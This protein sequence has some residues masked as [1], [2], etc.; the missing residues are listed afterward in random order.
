MAGNFLFLAVFKR[1]IRNTKQHSVFDPQ[2]F[3]FLCVN[4]DKKSNYDG[5][6]HD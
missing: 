2:Q 6:I 1:L 5:F 4:M 3:K